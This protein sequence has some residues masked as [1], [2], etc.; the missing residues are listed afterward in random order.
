MKVVPN[1]GLCIALWDIVERKQSFM[2]PGD[3]GH[4]TQVTFRFLVFRP[5]INQILVGRIKSCDHE[6]VR[7]KT[8]NISGLYK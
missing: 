4:H 1:V 5:F 8:K 6:S 7:G 2:L 3:S